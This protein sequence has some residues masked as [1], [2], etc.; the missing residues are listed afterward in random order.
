ML[1]ILSTLQIFNLGGIIA[2]T[3]TIRTTILTITTTLA[4][5]VVSHEEKSVM[6]VEKKIVA[7]ISI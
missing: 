3:N 1:P 7:L 6:F 2:E 4:T 5:M